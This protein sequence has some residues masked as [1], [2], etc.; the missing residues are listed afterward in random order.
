MLT[1]T[2]NKVLWL[3]ETGQ[4]LVATVRAVNTGQDMGLGG[5]CELLIAMPRVPDPCGAS[6]CRGSQGTPF[7]VKSESHNSAYWDKVSKVITKL[8][9]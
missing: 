8:S 4:A 5:F 2:L 7:V 6:R 9:L 1:Q 3:R